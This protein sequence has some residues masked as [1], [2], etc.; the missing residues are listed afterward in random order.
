M[1][2]AFR[3]IECLRHFEYLVQEAQHLEGKSPLPASTVG[4]ELGRFKIW[5]GNIGALQR[6]SR[7]LDYRLREASQVRDQVVRILKD[8]ESSIRE[9]TYMSEYKPNAQSRKLTHK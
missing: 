5:A 9:C 3:S 4:D 2:I 1:A 8:L 7:S 6:D